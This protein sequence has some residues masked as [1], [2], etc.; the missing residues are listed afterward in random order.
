VNTGGSANGQEVSAERRASDEKRAKVGLR[1]PETSQID[2][3]QSIVPALHDW[4]KENRKALTQNWGVKQ[5]LRGSL[6]N[7]GNEEM[8]SD[9]AARLRDISCPPVTAG[10]ASH[11]LRHHR[12][13]RT[14]AARLGIDGRPAGNSGKHG[15]SHECCEQDACNEFGE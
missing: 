2:L 4:R 9:L 15:G 13:F 8:G 1:A 6:G 5:G 3:G 10:P 14:S 11:R 7:D 12:A